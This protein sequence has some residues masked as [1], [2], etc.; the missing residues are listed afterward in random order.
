MS[1]LSRLRT[2]CTG[3]AALAIMGGLSAHASE[4]N[5]FRS[6]QGSWSGAGKIVAGKYKNT[7][8]TCILT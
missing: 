5:Y 3:I 8:F 2:T 1:F 7:I 6:V 4:R